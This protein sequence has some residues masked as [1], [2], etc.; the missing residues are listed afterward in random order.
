MV[1]QMGTPRAVRR[2]R[3]HSPPRRA[4]GRPKDLGKRQAILD[5]AAQLFLAH[6]FAGASMDAVA[7]AAGVSKVTVYAHFADKENLFSAMVRARCEA[8]NRPE[9]FAEYV[10]LP[11]RQALAEMGRNFLALLL[12][13]E[14]LQLYR[15][16]SA[17]ATRRPKVAVLFYAAGPERAIELFTDYFRRAAA[18][19]HFAVDDPEKVA[20]DFLALL[21]GRLHLRATLSL[22]SR[23]RRREIDAH[24]A[25]AVDVI[26]RAWAAR[27]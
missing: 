20:D 6:G 27:R 19:G 7:D 23:P 2:T 17:E 22:P 26:L 1:Q 18:R 10:D 8:Y 12:D 5:A 4:R 21:K 24:V 14:V 16:I 13:P 9:R 11:P 15:V 3:D 25:R